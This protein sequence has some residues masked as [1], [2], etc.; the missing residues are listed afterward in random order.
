MVRFRADLGMY[1]P[2]PPRDAP[3]PLLPGHDL[4]WDCLRYADIVREC[5]AGSSASAFPLR[6]MRELE[7][8]VAADLAGAAE[9]RWAS[10]EASLSGEER[11]ELALWPRLWAVRL[12]DHALLMEAQLTEDAGDAA[13]AL[14]GDA[15]LADVLA[16]VRRIKAGPD[17]ATRPRRSARK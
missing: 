9:R 5:T 13:E 2:A 17:A 15:A 11:A 4:G 14:G 12:R 8:R 3:P 6:F 16:Q 7:W 1:R 10:I